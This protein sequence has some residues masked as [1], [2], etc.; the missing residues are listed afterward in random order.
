MERDERNGA[1]PGQ[2]AAAVL[3]VLAARKPPRRLSVGK[4]SERIGIVAKRLLP[5]RLFEASAKSSLGVD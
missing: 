1:P 3:R 5:F 2:V 4:A